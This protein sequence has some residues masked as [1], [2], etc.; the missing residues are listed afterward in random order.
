MADEKQFQ[1]KKSYPF[2]DNVVLSPSGLD[3][4]EKSNE[5][6]SMIYG[7]HTTQTV[8]SLT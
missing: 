8:N 2:E 5:A 6:L 3:S 7:H 1:K 4:S